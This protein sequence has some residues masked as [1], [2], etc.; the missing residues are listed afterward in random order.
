MSRQAAVLPDSAFGSLTAGSR[1]CLQVWSLSEGRLQQSP[2]PSAVFEM[3]G[4]VWALAADGSR[5]MLVAGAA[6]CETLTC[7]APLDHSSPALT[8]S[9]ANAGTV[10]GTVSLFD[11]RSPAHQSAWDVSVSSSYI[12]GLGLMTDGQCCVC[13]VGDGRLLLLDLRRPGVQ[14]SDVRCGAP[15]RC[16]RMA[17]DTVVV[18]D[19]CGRVRMWDSAGSSL[20]RH[21]I[22]QPGL[23][24]LDISVPTRSAA[25]VTALATDGAL[26][27]ES[28]L[29]VAHED[30]SLSL[31]SWC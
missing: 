16:V 31:Q 27:S 6:D 17:R 5:Q 1:T 13:G 19:E 25:A 10:E 29:A 3:L 24:A 22:S 4:G 2:S 20:S 21:S 12:A 23:H 11:V 8:L 30:G 14:L 7:D 15:L 26:A 9:H 28:L 18:G